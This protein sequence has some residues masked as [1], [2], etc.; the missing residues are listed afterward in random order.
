MEPKIKRAGVFFRFG[1]SDLKP[2]LTDVEPVTDAAENS[3]DGWP[4][5]FACN[6]IECQVDVKDLHID[7]S[8]SARK[9][10]GIKIRCIHNRHNKR[11]RIQKKWDKKYGATYSIWLDGPFEKT[12]APDGTITYDQ[13]HGALGLSFGIDLKYEKENAANGT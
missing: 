13:R 11:K 1:D 5:S 7:Q 12:I 10:N 2:M 9:T 6:A 3:D 4:S 8:F